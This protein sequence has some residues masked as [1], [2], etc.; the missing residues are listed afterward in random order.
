M[1]QPG[2]ASALLT[3][4]GPLGPLKALLR[5]DL[6]NPRSSAATLEPRHLVRSRRRV[7]STKQVARAGGLDHFLWRRRT[8]RLRKD[9]AQR[10]RGSQPGRRG[11]EAETTR[12]GSNRTIAGSGGR[13]GGSSGDGS[14][15]QGAIGGDGGRGPLECGDTESDP[16]DCGNCG[17]ASEPC[18]EGN[19]LAGDGCEPTTC[20]TSAVLSLA[21][22]GGHSCA[23]LKG[24]TC[25]VGATISTASSASATPPTTVTKSLTKFRWWIWVAARPRSTAVGIIPA[26]CSTMA[27][28][29]AEDAI[30]TGSSGSATSLPSR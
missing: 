1:H 24:G 13:S 18:D 25:A 21:L 22:G 3:A 12:G 4:S 5:G 15:G 17:Q 14:S 19:A 20:Q 7:T 9:D 8:R 10:A 28:C 29:A 27:A 26:R 16:Q 30:S 6:V 2:G 23:L 11:G